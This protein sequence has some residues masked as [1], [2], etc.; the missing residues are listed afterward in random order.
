MKKSMNWSMRGFF[1]KGGENGIS[2]RIILMS[3]RC[4]PLPVCMAEGKQYPVKRS[5]KNSC[6]LRG[7]SK[8]K[9]QG[10]PKASFSFTGKRRL[11]V[12]SG[13]AAAL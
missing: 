3:E 10:K 9:I 2:D 5:G 6:I 1:R 7:G 11:S 4:F 12:Q 13:A 8:N